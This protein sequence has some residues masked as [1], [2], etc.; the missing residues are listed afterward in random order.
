MWSIRCCARR[1]SNGIRLNS[2]SRWSRTDTRRSTKCSHQS[3][4]QHANFIHF[5][6][7][8]IMRYRFCIFIGKFTRRVFWVWMNVSMNVDLLFRIKKSSFCV[9]ETISA[10]STKYWIRICHTCISR[11]TYLNLLLPVIPAKSAPLLTYRQ[12]SHSPPLS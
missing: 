3:L 9:T 7:R 2:R 12:I 11:K 1:F 8:S 5:N 4:L 10:L 6:V